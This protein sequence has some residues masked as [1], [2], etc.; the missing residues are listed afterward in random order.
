MQIPVDYELLGNL[1]S[2]VWAVLLFLT[3]ILEQRAISVERILLT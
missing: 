2:G 3:H 1:E